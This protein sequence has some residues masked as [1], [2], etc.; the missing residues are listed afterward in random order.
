MISKCKSGSMIND[1]EYV[2]YDEKDN[3]IVVCSASSIH[4][5]A[6]KLCCHDYDIK[7]MLY[8]GVLYKN[9]YSCCIVP[10]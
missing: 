2:V 6:M 9:R 4:L 8:K 7:N 10:V 1:V 3:G 5:L